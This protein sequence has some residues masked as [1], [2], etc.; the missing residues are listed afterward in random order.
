[1]KAAS[2]LGAPRGFYAVASD[3]LKWMTVDKGEVEAVIY[4]CEGT[5]CLQEHPVRLAP[6]LPSR[7]FWIGAE[8]SRLLEQVDPYGSRSE[9]G[10]ADNRT[11]GPPVGFQTPSDWLDSV[12]RPDSDNILL[13]RSDLPVLDHSRWYAAGTYLQLPIVVQISNS[14]ERC[15]HLLR[16]SPS[17]SIETR[18]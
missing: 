6:T 8:R 3:D 12:F 4:R 7:Y 13:P 18:T 11:E 15:P 14:I 2:V 5:V 10:D 17:P 9:R 16:L 1:V